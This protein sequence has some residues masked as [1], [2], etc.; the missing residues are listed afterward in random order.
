MPRVRVRLRIVFLP[1]AG[2]GIVSTNMEME[3]IREII[4]HETH[5]F[6]DSYKKDIL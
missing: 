3:L 2:L 5:P 1:S 6:N 4:S